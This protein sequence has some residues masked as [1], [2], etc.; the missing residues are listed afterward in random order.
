M[1]NDIKEIYYSKEQLNDIVV[2]LGKK[3][4]EDY[5]DKNLLLVCIL[6]GSVLFMADLMRAV[7]LPCKIDFMCVSSYGN[8][9]DNN[10]SEINIIKDID[11]NLEGFDVLLV[12]DILDSGRTLNC[13]KSVLQARNPESIRICT[14][15]DKPER[16]VVD[17]KADYSGAEVPDAFVVGYGLDYAEVYRNLPFI[18]VLREEIYTDNEEQ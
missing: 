7:T 17:I 4:S 13:V 10:S 18:G 6:K 16:R 15:L 14:L 8:G 11:D 5:K 3:I 12:E 2:R 1:I 9:T